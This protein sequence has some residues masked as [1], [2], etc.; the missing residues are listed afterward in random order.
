MARY[1]LKRKLFAGVGWSQQSPESISGFQE[2]FAKL[3]QSNPVKAQKLA[4]MG[5]GKDFMNNPEFQSFTKSRG[6]AYSIPNSNPS[7]TTTALVK[8]TPTPPV[9]PKPVTPPP[10]PKPTTQPGMLGKMWNTKTGK[11]GLVGAALLGGYGIGKMLSGSKD[12]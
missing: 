2:G 5:W 8:A 11:A 6:I 12:K 1:R 9:V 10:V 4:E 7:P 3:H